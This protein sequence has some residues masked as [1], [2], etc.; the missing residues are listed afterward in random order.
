LTGPPEPNFSSVYEAHVW[1]VYG[2]LAY[3]VRSRADAED[4]TQLTFERALGA[5][6][7]FDRRRASPRTWLLVIA[8]N[9]LIDHYRS[10]RSSLHEDVASVD[11]GQLGVTHI[12]PVLGI[13]A[14]LADGLATLN[15]RERE[16]VAL[17][18]GADLS[19][20]EIADVTGLSLANVQQISSRALRRLRSLLAGDPV[21]ETPAG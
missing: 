11:E 14:A 16:L 15:D 6:G 10:D 18:F 17:R 19:G 8:R 20:A 13:E 5:W 7:R 4:L 12:D 9:V 3:R 21:D 2:F 1:D